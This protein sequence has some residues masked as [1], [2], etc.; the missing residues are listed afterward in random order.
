MSTRKIGILHPGEMGAA[1]A[2]TARNSGHEVFWASEGR[3]AETG[4]RAAQTG[5]ADAGSLARLCHICEVIVSVCPPEFA[6]GMARQIGGLGFG[7]VYIDAN[8]ISPQRVQRIGDF[9]RGAG[10]RFVDGCIIGLPATTPGQTWIY[11]SGG[12]AGDVASCFTGGPLEVECLGGE[13]GKASALKMCFAAHTK[14]LAALRAAVLGAAEE[15]GVLADL[16]RQWSRSGPLFAQAV[17]SIQHTAP[18]AWRFVAEM[19]EIAETFESAGMPGEFHRAA[20]EIYSRL[21]PFKG[22]ASPKLSE[23]LEKLTGRAAVKA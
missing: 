3:S 8:A 5:L 1:V 23:A 7:G 20:G 11:L 17:A 19:Q 22:A 14:G 21:A 6:E 12:P 13:I 16:E 2:A 15:L 18:K 10:V 4:R 9:L